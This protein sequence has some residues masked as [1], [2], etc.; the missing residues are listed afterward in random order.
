MQYYSRSVLIS[1]IATQCGRRVRHS[2]FS[3]H[4]EI[5]KII[6][7]LLGDEGEQPEGAS[8]DVARA[9]PCWGNEGSHPWWVHSLG[10]FKD[11][12]KCRVRYIQLRL[13]QNGVELRP[14]P[15]STRTLLQYSLLHS[16]NS[17]RHRVKDLL[18]IANYRSR[19]DVALHYIRKRPFRR[20]YY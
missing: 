20:V 8:R 6:E 2:I 10:S 5:A 11:T 16:E 19:I 13:C 15:V 7:G 4:V 3:F 17:L 12:T 18:V 1:S 9:Q 14:H